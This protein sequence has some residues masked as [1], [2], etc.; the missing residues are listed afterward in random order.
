VLCIGRQC[1]KTTC[2]AHGA[3]Y[4]MIKEPGTDIVVASLSEDQAKLIIMMVLDILE[5]QYPKQVPKNKNKPTQNK[6]VLKNGSKIIA[7]PVGQ[8]GNAIRG[9]TG[10]I[11][12][13]DEVSRFNELIMEAATP[14]LMTTSGEIWMCSTPFGRRGFFYKAFVNKEERYKVW[15]LSAEDV[16]NSR[17]ISSSWTEEQRAGAIQ[18]LKEE[19]KDKTELQYRQEYMA[20]FVEDIRQFFPDE[21]IAKCC[22]KKRPVP[23]PKENNFLGVDIARLGGDLCAYEVLHRRKE[24][25]I[26]IENI[27]KKKQFTTKTEEDIRDLT[28]AFNIKKIGIDAGSGSLGVGIYDRLKQDPLTKRKV[29]AMNNRRVSLERDGSDKQRIFKEDMYENLLNMM[30]RKEIELLDDDDVRVAL[31][32]VQWEL[33]EVSHVTRVKIYGTDTHIV[34]GLI[35]AA[36]IAKKQKVFNGGLDYIPIVK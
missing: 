33:K 11:L 20:E 22:I 1:G 34:E 21:L 28:N 8:T 3:V 35:R 6:I 10:K 25:Y 2:M 29:V 27:T 16:I 36:W 32:S 5:K 23:Y 14:I 31:K 19:R 7:R 4:R 12:I 17:P 26:H 15:R 13:L 9:F 24:R 30:E 18:F